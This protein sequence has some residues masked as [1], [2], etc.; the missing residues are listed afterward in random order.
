MLDALRGYVQ[1][2][3]GLTEV[4]VAKAREAAAALLSQG[5]D[6]D[7]GR[8]RPRSRLRLSAATV[9]ASQVQDL[10]D[11][12]LET[13]KQNRELLTGL[14]RTEVD[15]AAGRHRL[16]ARGGARRR[17]PSR[18]TAG[19]PAR[20]GPCPDRVG[21]RRTRVGRGA[22][23]RDRGGTGEEEDPGEEEGRPRGGPPLRLPLSRPR[24]PRPT[25]P[26]EPSRDR[27]HDEELAD[28]VV[29]RS[30][31][32][33]SDD[34]QRETRPARRAGRRRAR[35]ARRRQRRGRIRRGDPGVAR[36]EALPVRAAPRASTSPRS[37]TSTITG[38]AAGRRGDRAAATRSPDLPTR[39][40][41][42]CTTTSTDGCR[43]RCPTPRCAEPVD[44][45]SPARRRAG[46]PRA[47]PLARAGARARR[48][49]P[50]RGGRRVA[51]QAGH[52]GRRRPRRSSCREP[53]D[54]PDYVSRGAHKLVGA[55]DAFGLELSSGPP[56]PRRRAPAPAGSPTC[57]CARGRRRCVAVD[58]GY[59]QLAWSLRTDER[60]TVLE[61]T[62]VRDLTPELLGGPARPRRG[63]PVVHLAAR[64][65]CPP[66]AAVCD[67]RTP[68][69]CSWSS[70][71]SRWARTGW[72]PAAWCATPR[73]GRGA[74]R[75]IAGA[76]LRRSAWACAGVVAS[77]LPGPCGQRRVLP[78]AAAR[79]P[80]RSTTPTWHARDRGGTAVTAV[81]T[82]ARR[83][84]LVA[85]TAR[86]PAPSPPRQDVAGR[87]CARPASRCGC[88]HDEADDLGRRGVVERRRRVRRRGLRDR[89]R[90]RRRR[91][92]AARAPS[93]P[94]PTGVPLLGVNLGHVGFLAEAERDDVGRGR[95]A[96]VA[97]R[98]DG[99]GAA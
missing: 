8:R 77:P 26:T 66:L 64:S 84:L 39:S 80:T 87:C 10:A 65:C 20:R 40:T 79:A 82:A 44:G 86:G 23:H 46:A 78:V 12:L 14:V 72:V 37:A 38:D 89:G 61:R 2:A 97:G 16:R 21:D 49:R 96:V 70:R 36:S 30:A 3:T 28:D 53:T 95:R 41:S 60:V 52:P 74:V 73:C 88:S 24:P 55:L 25:A 48:R 18:V 1:L 42:R 85:H 13:S 7:E 31:T 43:T 4:T 15:R 47:G 54:G 93:S 71:S 17:A 90:A 9:A 76:A 6:L 45:P 51:H 69:S 92:A 67:R 5:V 63:R 94:A 99:R 34:V 29:V 11:D 68:T 83:V 59:G 19:D 56:V 98:Y 58:V 81:A 75:R 62:N 50:G 57:C 32:G 27:Q 33:P 35:R 22:C 91:H